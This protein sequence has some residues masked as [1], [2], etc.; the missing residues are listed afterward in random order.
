MNYSLSPTND[1]DYQ[2][3]YEL[4]QA[5]YHDVVVEQFGNWDEAFQQ[6]LFSEN[7]RSRKTM[8]IE[9]EGQRVGLLSTE[10]REDHLWL[11]ELQ[12][13]PEHQNQGWGTRI[14]LD[15]LGK[16]RADK[17]PC[18]CR[19]SSRTTGPVSFTNASGFIT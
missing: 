7:W 4:N 10:M 19:C 15:Q 2:W 12:L 18:V 1:A 14:V 5:S 3:V 9:V 6:S 16:A 11:Q 13:L 8:L 17:K